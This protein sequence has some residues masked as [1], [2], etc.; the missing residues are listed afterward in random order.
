TAGSD[1]R[2]NNN[3][4]PQ[5]I[6]GWASKISAGPTSEASQKL[7]F[8][9]TGDTNPGLF[10]T[11]PAVDA[12]TG[13]LTFTPNPTAFGTA[14]ITLSLHD[15]GGTDNGG[16]DTSASQTFNITLNA[17]PVAKDVSYTL[18]VGGSSSA[19]ASDGVL[20]NSSDPDG[21][22]L[23]AKI[24]SQ[25]TYGSVTLNPDG[26]FTYT[27]GPSFAGIDSFTFQ[28]SDGSLASNTATVNIISYEASIVKKLY[29][30]VLGRDP[31]TGGLQFWTTQIEQGKPYSIIAQGIFESN[32]RLDPIIT[33]YYKQFLFRDP[34]PQGLAYWRDS[35][36]KVYG[37]P[38]RVIAGM[39]SSP[40]FYAS[41]GGT[42]TGWVK[43][44]YERLLN[45]QFDTQGLNYWVN[46]LG[47]QQQ[48]EF[49]VVMGFLTSDENYKLLTNQF[50]DEY[51]QRQPSQN[52]LNDYLAA[53]RAG[54]SQRDIQIKLIDTPEYRNSPPP[55]APG[56]VRLLT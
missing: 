21:D 36:W 5:S 13:A 48:T 23:T 50:F 34:D 24:I 30:Q 9:V 19:D 8:N 46:Q 52:E 35:V 54:A 16:Q 32:E 56:T 4:G 7:T 25:P 47:T 38:E 27:K 44:L 49:Q 28:A 18:S 31:D 53:F 37:G 20:A 22:T 11:P 41:A 39:M 2:V 29:E 6:A 43:A 55:P 10:A 12:A 17:G 3:A 51:L 33:N 42:D 26:S 40:E 1:V 45:R 14:A 15:D